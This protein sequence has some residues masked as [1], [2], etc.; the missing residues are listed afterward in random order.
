MYVGTAD[1]LHSARA[2]P[3][4][5]GSRTHL[6]DVL[7][8]REQTDDVRANIAR[9]EAR[10]KEMIA[11][12]DCRVMR[13]VQSVHEVSKLV[14]ADF[15]PA[16][17]A[18]RNQAATELFMA[19]LG[20]S[21][22]EQQRLLHQIVN[23]QAAAQPLDVGTQGEEETAPTDLE[24]FLA[25]CRNEAMQH[26]VNDVHGLMTARERSAV[27]QMMQD[28]WSRRTAAPAVGLQQPI[29]AAA[30]AAAA[31][32]GDAGGRST[33]RST[34]VDA[35]NRIGGTGGSGSGSG[36]ASSSTARTAT[37]RHI[38]DFADIVQTAPPLEWLERMVAAVEE[39]H[40]VSGS[41]RRLWRAARDLLFD[42]A[43]DRTRTTVAKPH[44]VA[45]YL[46]TSRRTLERDF[47]I[48]VLEKTTDSSPSQLEALTHMHAHKAMEVI[49]A[50]CATD[51]AAASPW[52]LA[53]YAM[54]CGRYDAA[55]QFALDGGLPACVAEGLELIHRTPAA[56]RNAIGSVH[57]VDK[58]LSHQETESDPY[59]CA[60]L[61]ILACGTPAAASALRAK[62]A[63]VDVA[64]TIYDTLWLRLALIRDPDVD[65]P[66][67]PKIHNLSELQREL[68]GDQ[69][70]LLDLVEGDVQAVIRIFM[71]ALLPSTALRALFDFDALFVDA[72]HL[73]LVFDACG[74]LNATTAENPVDLSRVLVRYSG[75]L[76]VMTKKGDG[77]HPA[78]AIFSYFLK[79]HQLAAFGTLCAD[80]A[81]CVKLFGRGDSAT[82]EGVLLDT[83]PSNEL[84][85][86][87]EQIASKAAACGNLTLAVHVLLVLEALSTSIKSEPRAAHAISSA[88]DCVN[89][90]MS[91]SAHPSQAAT[92]GE[93]L[94][95][96]RNLSQRIQHVRHKLPSAEMET[97]NH[98][99]TIVE[100][101]ELAAQHEVDKAIV[102]FYRLPF[103]PQHVGQV[104]AKAEEF[105]T[106]VSD[107]VV[108][109]MQHTIPAV[110]KL[111]VAR[112]GHEAS[113]AERSSIQQNAAAL[114]RWLGRWKYR[115]GQQLQ[116]QVADLER[117]LN[118]R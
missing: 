24:S 59:R 104:E 1:R 42:I 78:A 89:L 21:L 7:Q 106:V 85:D 11:P 22:Q 10:A 38:E 70:Y 76:L 113:A 91:Q 74:L 87:M 12:T 112:Y 71:L 26:A 41:S 56:E 108:S 48:E 66:A 3:S 33:R 31:A 107:A 51:G 115:L 81:T 67:Q 47:F 14:R 18:Q 114:A 72:V 61:Q 98:L 54:R 57:N 60:V 50:F 84:L 97:F 75:S 101:L 65:D 34:F 17:H 16:N 19:S 68:L 109:S 88:L 94:I 6:E 116:S 77:R 30:A 64:N 45:S 99:L 53:Y 43:R 103:V 96:A 63:A 55:Q 100:F 93:L 28:T 102:L 62:R 111:L 49:Y 29:F 39:N 110:M 27:E 117:Q 105:N 36:T 82:R 9:L 5:K 92:R 8:R 73:A 44:A 90:A 25:R 79:S 83:P 2:G 52:V 13:T 80:E 46:G 69:Q 118:L 86:A 15:A 4:A 35:A 58:A 37:T 32:G 23:S 95:I 40:E 20:F